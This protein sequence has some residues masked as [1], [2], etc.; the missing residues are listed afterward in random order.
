MNNKIMEKIEAMKVKL[1]E[2]IA[3]QKKHI[4][5]EIQKSNF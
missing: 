1:G 3:Q 4:S 5:Y 2:G